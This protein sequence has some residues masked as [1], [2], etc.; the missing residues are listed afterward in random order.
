MRTARI[1]PVGAG[2]YYHIMNR[3]AGEPGYYPFDDVAREK[4]VSLFREV[5]TLYTVEPIAFQFLG[6]HWHAI[7]YAPA[8]CPNP[9]ETVKRYNQYYKDAKP[10]ITPDD[11]L[12][13]NLAKRL[14][15]ISAFAGLVQ[16]RFATWFN[17]HSPKKRRGKLWGDRFKSTILECGDAVWRCLCYV[18]MNPVRAHLADDPA[19]YRFGSW[20][21][22]HGTEKHPFAENFLKHMRACL[23]DKAANWTI[24]QIR[25]VLRVELA[26]AQARDDKQATPGSV[27]STANAARERPGLQLTVERRCR[28]WSDGLIIGCKTFVL[29]TATVIR[30]Q[31][32]LARHRIQKLQT[33]DGSGSLCAYRRL[34]R[35]L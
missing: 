35:N 6:N 23:G 14:N 19:N 31:A 10:P 15:S 4:M 5:A 8:E 12:I 30:T 21:I 24:E 3:I 33:T 27:E 26:R 11:P 1:K 22:W 25:D 29:E 34:Q 17:R 18:E 20:G 13:E 2:V 32:E 28:F 9:A 16:Q 7:I